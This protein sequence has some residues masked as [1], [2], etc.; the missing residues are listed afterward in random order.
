MEAP[1]TSTVDVAR[2]LIK[3]YPVSLLMKDKLSSDKALQ[4]SG[5]PMLWLHGTNDAIIPFDMGQ[6]LFDNYDG[7]KKAHAIEGGQDAN[8]WFLGGREIV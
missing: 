7:P 2:I 3:I 6:K 1:F 4:A 5:I 8:I